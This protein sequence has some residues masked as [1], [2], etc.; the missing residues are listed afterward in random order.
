MTPAATTVGPCISG[1]WRYHTDT[2]PYSAQPG[3]A[4]KF[5][6]SLNIAEYR[7]L[8]F[9][10]AK[11][12]AEGSGQGEIGKSSLCMC[13]MLAICRETATLGLSDGLLVEM[14]FHGLSLG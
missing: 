1:R 6:T 4:I 13:R 12:E 8:S 3:G 7:T 10:F 9:F 14:S 2:K 5:Q 11:V